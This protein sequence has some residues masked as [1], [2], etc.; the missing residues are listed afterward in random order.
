MDIL[1]LLDIYGQT[2][3]ASSQLSVGYNPVSSES[4]IS[5]ESYAGQGYQSKYNL[6]EVNGSTVL[7]DDIKFICYSAT[8]PFTNDVFT[9]NNNDYRVMSVQSVFKNETSKFYVCQLRV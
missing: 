9:V 8:T 5:S 1:R 6:M 3:T 7:A 4:I 2:F